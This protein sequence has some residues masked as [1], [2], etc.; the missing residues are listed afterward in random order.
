[1]QPNDFIGIAL[2]IA[3]FFYTIQ[4]YCEFSG[5]SEIAIETTNLFG[6]SGRC[7]LLQTM[8]S[9]FCDRLIS[10]LLIEDFKKAAILC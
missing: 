4:I 8:I 6:N 7:L 10:S 5:Y 2:W 9:F 1:M 3:A